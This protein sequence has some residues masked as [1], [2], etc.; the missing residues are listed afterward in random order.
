MNGEDAHHE[1]SI[2]C[3][4]I[5]RILSALAYS[6]E[7]LTVRIPWV[8]FELVTGEQ[9]FLERIDTPEDDAAADNK[10]AEGLE[11]WGAVGAK[12]EHGVGVCAGVV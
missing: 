1:V 7:K 12:S 8:L 5:E 11:D 2:T 9:G 4:E 6:C 3:H 10:G